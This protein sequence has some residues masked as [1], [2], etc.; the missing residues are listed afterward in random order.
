ML[1]G[2]APV[3]A[4]AAYADNSVLAQG[5]WAKIRVS[6]TGIHRLT[7]ATI[8]AAGFSDLSKVRIYGYGG[9]LV[10]ERL[11]QEWISEHDDLTEI[12]TCTKDGAKYFYAQG[13]VSWDSMSATTR[14]RNPYSD[15]GYYFITQSDTQS[16]GENASP[17]S[18]TEEELLASA[19]E[20]YENYHYLYENDGY[21]WSETGRELV[22]KSTIEAGN[23]K[24]I[25]VSVP[26][27][28]TMANLHVRM[29]CG[30]ASSYRVATIGNNQQSATASFSNSYQVANFRSFYFGISKAM[31]D[32]LSTRDADGNYLIPVTVTCTSGGP[33]RTDYVV[34][35]YN[36]TNTLPAL[37]T[38]AYPAAEY[39][40]NITNQNHHAED[41]VDM[42]III[43]TNQN[44]LSAAENLAQLHMDVDTMSVR[45]VPADELY[46]EFSSG[47]PDVSAY[48]RYLKMFYDRG[49]GNGVK[50]VLLFGDCL[51]DNRLITVSGYDAD[52]LLLGYETY[53]S[54]NNT[55]SAMLDDF[56][57]VMDDGKTVHGDSNREQDLRLAVSSGRLPV[58]SAVQAE[59]VVNK[60]K[61]YVSQSGAGAWMNDIM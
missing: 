46:N 57:C 34:A 29:S 15:Y 4:W 10:P 21:A 59:N 38:E 24:T 14:T 12:P 50:Y 44:W 33:L 49:N 52:N 22:D 11:T 43:P 28:A 42:I 35:Q 54:E 13:P 20:G 51:W 36:A 25:D 19:S 8:Q 58:S 53:A 6:K 5:S 56:I 55:S 60:I 1:M 17:A 45:I 47:T 37:S 18:C 39:F 3:S 23:S 31:L 16:G 48:K 30:S 7:T 27:D 41:R 26:K 61:Q 9:A 40:C 32:T 2:I